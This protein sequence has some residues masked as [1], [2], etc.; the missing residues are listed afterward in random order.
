M[1]R[2]GFSRI[3]A[4]VPDHAVTISLTAALVARVYGFGHHLSPHHTGWQ[5]VLFVVALGLL[6]IPLSAALRQ[7]AFEA[8]AQRQVRDTV[9]ARFPQ[10]SRLSQVDIDFSHKPMQ[11]RAVMLTPDLIV[12]ADQLLAVD[13]RERL[14]RPVN[15]HV[16]QLRTSDAGAAEAAQIAR[17]NEAK[18]GGTGGREQAVGALALIAGRDAR[19]VLVAAEERRLS[20]EA[21]PLP[22]LGLEGYRALESRA[23]RALPGWS[24]ALAPPAN[25]EPPAIS[26]D[27]GVIDGKALDLASWASARLGGAIGVEGGTA[28]QRTAIVEG[29]AARGGRAK[30]GKKSGRLLLQWLDTTEVEK[31][32]RGRE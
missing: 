27:Q 19:A 31:G 5:L 24:V 15:I 6:S 13:L 8:V 16:D 26:F 20:V 25:V 21:A 2:H 28:A 29:I 10:G 32:A 9:R 3:V 11:V 22:G 14:G 30:A 1:E 18:G 17:A 23:A 4:V 7:I 12:R